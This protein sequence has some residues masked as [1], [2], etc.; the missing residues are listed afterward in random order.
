MKQEVKTD[1]G[2]VRGAYRYID[3]NGIVQMVE[4]IADALGFRVGATNLP[5]HVVDSDVAPIEPATETS[6]ALASAPAPAPVLSPSQTPGP[7][8][9][10]SVSYAYLPYATDYAYNENSPAVVS[11]PVDQPI[12]ESAPTYAAVTPVVAAGSPY[13][14][15]ISQYLSLIHI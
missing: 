8:M 4:Y 15:S 5:V 11:T 10:P 13:D 3:T 14:S 1:D 6:A 12:V 7:A 9:T 2:V